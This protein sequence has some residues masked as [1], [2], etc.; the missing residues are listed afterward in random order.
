LHGPDHLAPWTEALLYAAARAELVERIL[1]P[2]L[3][4][5]RVLVLDRYIDSSLAYQ[6]HARGLGIDAVLAV[7]AP[8]IAGVMP[9]LTVVIVVDPETGLARREGEADRIEREGLDL[10]RRV[11]DG[12]AELA[13]REPARVRLVD[14]SAPVAAVAAAVDT[15]VAP[16]LEGRRV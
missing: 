7:N 15:L 9:D 12:F 13:R 5:G 16:L 11:A 10:Q 2:S 6:G 3:E 14:G 4:A 1:R 8:G